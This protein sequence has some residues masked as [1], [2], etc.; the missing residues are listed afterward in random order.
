MPRVSPSEGDD[1]S[2][3]PEALFGMAEKFA[4][5]ESTVYLAN[6]LCTL[7]PVIREFQPEDQTDLAASY[8]EKVLYRY[9][10]P[11]W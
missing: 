3:H 8:E 10:G 6:Q 1:R 7:L 5:A 2:S 4:A 11:F 9:I